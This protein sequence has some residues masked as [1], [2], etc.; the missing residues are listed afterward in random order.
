MNSRSSI[1]LLLLCVPALASDLDSLASRLEALAQAG[2][3]S[4][5]SRVPGYLS[6]L[7]DSGRFSDVD[8]LDGEG[9]TTR[10]TVR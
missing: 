7:A 5:A 9:I 8:C 2:S 1:I 10:T 4:A 6:I 3:G